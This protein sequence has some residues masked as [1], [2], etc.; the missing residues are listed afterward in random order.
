[1]IHALLKASR[2]ALDQLY[3]RASACLGCGDPLHAEVRTCLCK[4][5][6]DAL[7]KLRIPDSACPHCMSPLD[8]RGRC[9]FC[10]GHGLKGLKAGYGAYRYA[11]VAR[12]LIWR[13]K[14]FWQDEAAQALCD[15]MRQLVPLGEYDVLTPVPLYRKRVR[16]RGC[17]QAETLC[18]LLAP[19]LGMPVVCALIRTRNT[20]PQVTLSA[21]QRRKNVRHAFRATENVEGLR[22]L[23]VDDIR[24]TG[25]TAREC[26]KELTRA[27]AKHVSILTAAI[28]IKKNDK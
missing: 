24:T 3:P 16:Y 6:R 27:G 11:G 13:L 21:H 25:A 23:L 7:E 15:S 10:R 19:Q 18:R 26:A 8:E 22:I 4:T 2:K 9:A 17:N 20:A 14:F 1:M 5:C 28:A 12:K